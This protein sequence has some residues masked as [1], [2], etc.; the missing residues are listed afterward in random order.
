MSYDLYEVLEIDSSASSGDVKKAYRKLAL[1]YHPDKVTEEE[2]EVAEIKFKEISHAY[3]ILSDEGRRLEYDLY[4]EADGNGTGMGDYDS[5]PFGNRNGG[6][7]YTGEDFFNYFESMNGGGSSRQNRPQRTPD[8]RMELDVTLEDLFKGKTVKITSTREIICPGCKG[9]GAKK[10]AVPKTCVACD[11]E[12]TQVK[13]KRVGPGLV[14]QHHVTCDSCKGKGKTFRS[15]DTCKLCSGAFVVEETKILEFE[16][17]P[18]SESGESVVLLGE[19][20]QYPGKVTG[21]VILTFHAKEHSVFTRKEKD[22]FMKYK[23]TLVDALSG[24]SKVVAMHLD[25]RGIHISTPKGKVVRPGDFLKIKG[26]GMP[27]KSGAA[28][29][30][31]FGPRRGDLYVEMEIEFP[32]DNWYLEKN[33]LTKLKNLFPTSLRDKQ[34]A[35]KQEIPL[36]SLPEANIE[37]VTEFGVSRKETL[38]EYKSEQNG[39]SHY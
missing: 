32:Q 7:E 25:G 33:D 31:G 19:A 12:G 30:F 24:F 5:N 37:Y 2:R 28:G 11:G 35:R 6:R 18:G 36:E 14:A 23:I 39:H 1:R 10:K 8:A 3:E 34:D 4:G 29:W 9:T 38:P 15:K 22:L 20:D 26:E 27:T 16:I 21:D 17:V 13:I